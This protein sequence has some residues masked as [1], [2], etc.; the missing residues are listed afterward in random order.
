[1]V[2]QQRAINLPW[3]WS[4]DVEL[5][6][7]R[8]RE[9]IKK[10]NFPSNQED[11]ILEAMDIANQYHAHQERADGGAYVIH[12]YRVA[13]SLFLEF[14]E[15]SFEL[16][17][18]AL[19]HDLL[20]DTTYPRRQMKEKFGEK[21]ERLVDVVSR[22]EDEKRPKQGDQI[23]DK[24]F[25]KILENGADAIKLKVAD[26]L[27]NIRDALNHPKPEK[28]RLYI[29][30]CQTIF[31]PLLKYLENPA[32][33]KKLHGLIEEAMLNHPSYID[34]LLLFNPGLDYW[35]ASDYVQRVK[36]PLSPGFSAVD[37]VKSVATSIINR[38][39]NNRMDSL[40]YIAN[41][42]AFLNSSGKKDSWDRVKTQLSILIELLSGNTPPQWLKP[43]MKNPEYLLTVVHSRFFMPA[44]WLF[45]LWQKDYGD[46][47]LETN[48]ELYL[49]LYQ[50]ETG[51]TE[52]WQIWLH[53]LL[54]HREAL[55]RLI[56]GNGCCTAHIIT[57]EIKEAVRLFGPEE[58]YSLLVSMRLLA[59][60]LDVITDTG[61]PRQH[62]E[63]Y[64]ARL[65]DLL[66]K[67]EE[68]GPKKLDKN[69]E[70]IGF[71]KVRAVCP[72]LET[73]LSTLRSI[74]EEYIHQEIVNGQ[75]KEKPS[76]IWINFNVSEI[77]KRLK[78]FQEALKKIDSAKTFKD[79][80][81]I[82]IHVQIDR[83]EDVLV[84]TVEPD[85][86]DALK[87]RIPEIT[88]QER[89]EIQAHDYSAAAI[90]DTLLTNKLE[91]TKK[92]PIWIPRVYRIL[93]TMSDFD[94]ANVQPITISFQAEEKIKDVQVYLPIPKNTGDVNQQKKRKEITARYIV[95]TIYN[96]VVT[97]GIYSA[98]V[99]CS[100]LEEQKQHLGFNNHEL[101]NMLGKMAVKLNYESQYS[102]YVEKF[103]FKKFSIKS[104]LQAKKPVNF[105]NEDINYGS[106]LGI[107][108]GGTDTKVSLFYNGD[109]AINGKPLLSFKS[110]DTRGTDI[111]IP[112]REFCMRIIDE[113]DIYLNEQGMNKFSWE[114]LQ[115]VGIS[116]P[117]G[118][119]NSKIV[120]Y[121]RVLEK[122][123]FDVG[124]KTFN[125]KPDSSPLEIHSVDLAGVFREELGKKFKKISPSFVVAVENDGNSEAYGN[126]CHLTKTGGQIPGGKLIIKLG[127]STAG[128]YV[129]SSSALSPLV[130]EF[131]K[132]I[133]DFNI[134]N[135]FS[136]E[137]QG[138]V[139]EF[140]SSKAVRNL[141][142][143]FQFNREL[144]FGSM[145]CQCCN[146][147]MNESDSQKT[148][149]EA[150]E[151]GKLLNFFARV[152]N[153]QLKKDFLKE[154]VESDNQ[155]A[156]ASYGKLIEI[157]AGSLR[158][159]PEMKGLLIQYVKDRG[160]E[161]FNR[162]YK[163]DSKIGKSKAL[164]W[165]LGKSRLNLL[166][167]L[168]SPMDSN[169]PGQIPDNF[170][171]KTF[172]KKILGAVALFS[173]V[174]MHISHLVAALYNIFKKERFNGVI[175]SGGVLRN[176]TGKV[177]VEQTEGFLAKYYDK[178]FGAQ[179][180]LKPGSVQLAV[181]VENPDTVGPF[182]AAMVANRIHK[183]N[184]LAVM[185]KEI[186]YRVRKLKPGDTI[187]IKDLEDTF[188]HSRIKKEDLREYLE[189]L[190][191]K[192]IL[193]QQDAKKEVYVKALTSE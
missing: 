98:S 147:A 89:E 162:V 3:W 163:D 6:S 76:L 160:E 159:N 111:T 138:P 81:K 188:K 124:E 129:H 60:Y 175:L 55:W 185:E 179:K 8:L 87:N 85:K 65:W 5:T 57:S 117:G 78:F 127:T 142:R 56:I 105:T 101:E 170:D 134:K 176:E 49:S 80:D 26:K 136:P 187:S 143:T 133:L 189:L 174:G 77:Q 110:F 193:L 17:T 33:E 21:V 135:K 79:L 94:S 137:I 125:I 86:W 132:I 40:L 13:L 145:V 182:G 19:F 53:L 155:Y 28:R 96:H 14:Q 70:I 62:V 10:R 84:F 150:I 18:A 172:A 100:P 112:A 154:L 74:L 95:T 121:S 93:D 99:D 25:R 131:A 149:I 103:N 58:E 44:N 126:Y 29:R 46:H 122:I 41:L 186:D 92:E 20:E 68:P 178:I 114:S 171:F 4:G 153:R 15:S 50:S 9:E 47:I 35:I 128:G 164:V 12:A 104:A 115:G 73:P 151:I 66:N 82:G 72:G 169:E 61:V 183:I 45:P 36:I 177:I 180:H 1:M 123:L 16:V 48:I 166:F 156:E 106:F 190:I 113:V 54:I 152:Q 102:R 22:E 43:I 37:L 30:E 118:V 119:R 34:Q 23:T 67:P 52:K 88:D 91:R 2:E 63:E 108:I 97:L 158:D 69:V 139:R 173:Q 148:R 161:E 75:A 130:T 116:W 42:P 157:L 181:A 24:Y 165:K 141:S 31:L 107:D 39:N 27:D 59:E 11:L 90:F 83:L 7:K 51:K 146:V 184:S 120:T 168:D 144:V 191:S 140:V 38:I 32:L 109:S 71:E 192:S 64:F 167:Q